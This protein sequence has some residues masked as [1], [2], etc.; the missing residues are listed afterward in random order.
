M[1]IMNNCVNKKKALQKK[2]LKFINK[3]M[4]KRNAMMMKNRLK[5]RQ[6]NSI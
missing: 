3:M 4:M 2:N 1:R 5:R 6:N